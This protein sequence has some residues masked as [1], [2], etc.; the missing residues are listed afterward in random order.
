MVCLVFDSCG[1]EIHDSVVLEWKSITALN[2]VLQ[3][4]CRASNRHFVGLPLCEIHELVRL[5]NVC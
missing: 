4:V 3:V 5:Y 1:A 2:S